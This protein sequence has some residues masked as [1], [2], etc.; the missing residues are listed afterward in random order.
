VD[1][2][3]GMPVVRIFIDYLHDSDMFTSTDVV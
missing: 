2:L 1:S 3:E